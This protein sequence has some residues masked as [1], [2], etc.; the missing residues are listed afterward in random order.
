MQNSRHKAKIF[1]SCGQSTGNERQ[2]AHAIGEKLRAVGFEVD[3]AIE[4]ESLIGL[5]ENIFQHLQTSDYFL[6]VDFCRD[7]LESG[8]HRGSLFCH[9][10]LAVAS[11]L[12]LPVIGFR[13]AGVRKLDGIASFIQSNFREFT[14]T[15]NLPDAIAIV[16]RERGWQ[17]DCPNC[18]VLERDPTQHVDTLRRPLNR[19]EVLPAA[20][21]PNRRG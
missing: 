20:L 1:L 16:V 21:F 13:Q 7:K 19:E 15:A 17:P 6:F 3:V 10:E 12:D 8:E 14:D 9:Q 5:K 4:E 18:L 2:T 11:F